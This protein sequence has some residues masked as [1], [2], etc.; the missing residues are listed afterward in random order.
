MTRLIFRLVRIANILP[1]LLIKRKGLLQALAGVIALAL[2]FWGWSIFSPAKTMADHANNFFRTVQLMTL[3]F[4]TTFDGKLPWQLQLARLMVPAIAAL[5][6]LH[7]IIGAITRPVRIALLPHTKDHLVVCGAAQL[8][9]AALIKLA[10]RGVQVIAIAPDMVD[11]RRDTLEGYGLTVIRANPYE[12]ATMAALNLDRAG[13]IFIAGEDDLAN[14]NLAML[15][16]AQVKKRPADAPPMTLGILIDD[17]RLASE[18]DMALDG[19]SRRHGVRYHRICPDREGARLELERYAP[20]LTKAD[21][22]QRSHVLVYGLSGRWQQVLMQAIIACQDQ[23]DECPLFTLI[24]DEAETELFEDWQAT[25]SDRDMIVEFSI[26]AADS[27]IFGDEQRASDWRHDN[28]VPHLAIV[29]REKSDA[30]AAMLTLRRPGN[31]FGTEHTPLIVRQATEDRL[32]AQLMNTSVNDRD[33]SKLGVF[34]GLIRPDSVERVLDRKGDRIGIAMHAWYLDAAAKTGAGS[35]AAL[36]AWDALPENLRDANRAS[37]AH[38]PILFASAGF[39]L[40]KAGKGIEAATP[41]ETEIERLAQIEHRRWC[42]DRI[43]RGWRFGEP[44]D[45]V[46]KRHPSLKPYEDLSEAEKEKDRN[47]V[48]ALVSILASEGMILTRK[49]VPDAPPSEAA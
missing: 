34:G 28:P 29:L 32:V 19:I 25:T 48:R 33:F 30:I 17:E 9:E 21:P 14:L 4:P 3:N 1:G 42:A 8:T 35:A 18:L 41:D 47:A 6:T 5:A 38:A 44:R 46:R 36:A 11:E 27:D 31:P 15:A 37:A 12:P 49:I 10:E 13:A 45:D 43:D 23:P 39:V 26:I 16:M 40:T 20:A 2:G 24:L 22:E 7:V